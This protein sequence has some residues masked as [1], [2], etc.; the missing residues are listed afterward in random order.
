MV[1]F[2]NHYHQNDEEARVPTWIGDGKNADAEVFTASGSQLDVVTVVVVNSGLGQHGV[3]LDLA[4]TVKRE[5]N[6]VN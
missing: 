5:W 2:H 6:W 1:A 3:V 4:F